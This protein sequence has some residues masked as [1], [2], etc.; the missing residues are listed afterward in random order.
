MARMMVRFTES[1]PRKL[2]GN[3]LCRMYD[4]A[5]GDAYEMAS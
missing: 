4:E 1:V 2:W 3:G 5:G